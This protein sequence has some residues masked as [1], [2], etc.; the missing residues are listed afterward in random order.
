MHLWRWERWWCDTAKMIGTME[1]GTHEP[2]LRL[3]DSFITR[4]A[5]SWWPLWHN[6]HLRGGGRTSL[7]W[8]SRLSLQSQPAAESQNVSVIAFMRS[9]FNQDVLILLLLRMF[10]ISWNNI[11][12]RIP[13]YNLMFSIFRKIKTQSKEASILGIPTENEEFSFRQENWEEKKTLFE[14]SS[15]ASSKR[16]Q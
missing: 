11:Y 1:T 16:N 2:R 15:P 8:A 13:L 9:S 7:G 12:Y 4:T 6:L 14:I 10:N 5:R 3:S